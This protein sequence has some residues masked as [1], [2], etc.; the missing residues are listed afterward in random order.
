MAAISISYNYKVD[1]KFVLDGKE[2]PI[3]TEGITSI[4]TN[5]DYENNNIPVIYMGIRLESS[6]YN[7]MT[8]NADKGTITLTISKSKTGGNNSIYENYIQDTFIYFMSDD[9]DYNESLEKQSGTEDSVMEN[10]KYGYMALIQQST[11]N[12]NKKITNTIIRNSNMASIIHKY[13]SHMKMVMEPLHVDKEFKFLFI[14]PL[15]SISKLLEFLNKQSVFYRK[16][17]RY[18]VD[19]D[20]TYLLS[21][22]GNPIDIK[23][24]N[25]NTI[26]IEVADKIDIKAT[27]QGIITDTENKAYVLNINPSDTV[28]DVNK[29][30]DKIVNNIIGV[31]SYGNTKEVDL[32]IFKTQGGDSKVRIERVPSDNMEYVDYLKN[33]IEANSV[34]IT[35]QKTEIDSSLI[36]PNKEYLIRNY[37]SLSEY[38]G[39]YVLSFK[40]E[41]FIRKDDTFVNNTIF[42]IRKV[43]TQ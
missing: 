40:K 18:F 42:G 14:P 17:Y 34:L 39:R 35:I 16:G 23:D 24:G 1:A 3:L 41:T 31:D 27:E 43:K 20:K 15:D 25:Y 6:L 32:D 36:T 38:D 9:P 11:T 29:S 28:L 30:E 13:T 33:S 2:E 5:Y 4:I 21:K 10:Y 26:I 12:N 22:E 7:K 8:L 19:F 37:K